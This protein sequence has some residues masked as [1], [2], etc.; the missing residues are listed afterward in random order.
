MVAIGW[1]LMV[2]VMCASCLLSMSDGDG[3]DRH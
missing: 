3:H 1:G 2:V